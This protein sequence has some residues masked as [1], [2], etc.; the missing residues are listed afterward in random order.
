MNQQWPQDS[1][2]IETIGLN[3]NEEPLSIANYF[4]KDDK[5]KALEQENAELKARVEAEIKLKSKWRRKYEVIKPP[6]P[7]RRTQKSQKA[8][9]LI[10]AREDGDTTYTLTDISKLLDMPYSTIKSMAYS[11]R[12]AIKG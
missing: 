1:T 6:R 10:A 9:D 4:S 5:I 11:Y 7:S 2:K 12:Q 3:G 8:L